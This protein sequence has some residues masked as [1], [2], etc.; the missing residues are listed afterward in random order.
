MYPRETGINFF[1]YGADVLTNLGFQTTEIALVPQE[2]PAHTGMTI[3]LG[4]T[5]DQLAARPDVAAVFS[6]PRIKNVLITTEVSGKGTVNGWELPVQEAFTPEKL[7]R[8]YQEYYRFASELLTRYSDG[9]KEI[10]ILGTNEIDWKALG[11]TSVDTSTDLTDHA[12]SNSKKYLDAYLTAIRDANM[13]HSGK[14]PLRAAVEINRVRDIW[15]GNRRI[16]NAVIPFLEVQPDI[17]AYSAYDTLDKGTLFPQALDTIRKYAPGSEIVISEFG[18]PENR[19]DAVSMGREG[20]AELYRQRIQECL[21]AGIKYFMTWQ[22]T[23]NECDI[24]NPNNDQCNGFWM[25]RP[26]GSLS[27]NYRTIRQNFAQS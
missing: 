13:N 23:D 2:F 27:D 19:T 6:H 15:D 1:E 3:E 21:D 26:D 14:K 17:I 5:L 25:V 18:K 16:L 11:G 9:D 8:T 12:I 24:A 10:V 20:V 4:T 7:E 22:L